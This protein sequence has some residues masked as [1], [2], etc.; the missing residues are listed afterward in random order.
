MA[1][2]VGGRVLFNECFSASYFFLPIL[3]TLHTQ[4]AIGGV[5]GRSGWKN[6]KR[7]RKCEKKKGERLEELPDQVA[8]LHTDGGWREVRGRGAG[9]CTTNNIFLK[10]RNAHLTQLRTNDF[11]SAWWVIAI[12]EF[13]EQQQRPSVC[14]AEQ[15]NTCLSKCTKHSL[16]LTE[17]IRTASMPLLA[18]VSGLK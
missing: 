12:P 14:K 10:N 16:Q 9:E 5:D 1:H 2:F 4:N 3:S 7:K 8:P 17:H 11:D 13:A 6:M 18:T 15:I